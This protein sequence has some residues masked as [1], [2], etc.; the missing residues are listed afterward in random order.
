MPFLVFAQNGPG[1]TG[2][3]DGSSSLVLWLTGDSLNTLNNGN[4]VN[5]WRDLSGYGHDA[6]NDSS[7]IFAANTPTFLDT[8]YNGSTAIKAVR[9]DGDDYYDNAHTYQARTVFVV[10]NYRNDLQGDDDL[11]QIWGAYGDGVHVAMDTRSGNQDGL[12]FDGNTSIG[13]QGV[14]AYNSNPYGA[15]V[16]NSNT[17]PFVRNQWQ[18]L[19]VAFNAT[20]TLNRQVMGSLLPNFSISAHNLDADV[21][22]LIV[23]DRE[24][25]APERVSVENYLSTKYGIDISAPGNDH[26]GFDQNY[27]GLVAGI[28]RIGS[29]YDTTG[30]SG[31]LGLDTLG[32]V[33]IDDGDFA[34]IGH[35]NASL[36]WTTAEEP[37]EGLSNIRRVSREW[38]L[39]ETNTFGTMKM[40]VDTTLLPALPSE[41]DTYVLLVDADG[42][43]TDAN[44]YEMSR[45]AGTSHWEVALD[46]ADETYL[47]VGVV[48]PVIGF[49]SASQDDFETV[50]SANLEVRTNF[51]PM[52]NVAFSYATSDNGATAG[53]DYTAIPLTVG[54]INVG[55][56]SRTLPLTI[57]NDSD[58]EPG[59]CRH[60]PFCFCVQ[61]QWTQQP[62]DLYHQRR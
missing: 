3:T 8:I 5:A 32:S 37:A 18:M 62:G 50:T 43:F 6:N 21:A 49:S 28:G 2:Q 10:F 19:S 44:V 15:S 29:E 54:N 23:F 13:N 1:G 17:P 14:F 33:A 51:R 55:E 26:Y 27:P 56:N 7:Y 52:D 60:H 46:L 12:S 57:I 11:G 16:S 20:R 35:D 31:V 24:L 39:D 9:F 34:F 36:T 38:R 58:S 45:I 4:A 42:D 25:S 40:L 22:E 48:R 30:F 61:V 41:Y 53:D 47:S 59:R